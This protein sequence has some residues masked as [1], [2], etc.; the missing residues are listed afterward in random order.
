MLMAQLD[1]ISAAS[2]AFLCLY[3]VPRQLFLL[4][5]LMDAPAGSARLE[6]LSCARASPVK[7]WRA[8]YHIDYHIAYQIAGARATPSTRRLL[9]GLLDG[10]LDGRGLVAITYQT[11]SNAI[12]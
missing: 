2:P 7:A 3:S 4:H 6:P 1:V 5:T 11:I 8:A 9:G 12:A 10:L